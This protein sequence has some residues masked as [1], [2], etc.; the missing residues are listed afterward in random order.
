MERERKKKNG[1]VLVGRM[2][3]LLLKKARCYNTS[4][5]KHSVL[6]IYKKFKLVSK[7]FDLNT[8]S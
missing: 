3:L 5:Y 2:F 6:K 7:D 1:T 4:K 8:H